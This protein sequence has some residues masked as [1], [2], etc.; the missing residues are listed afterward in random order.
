MTGDSPRLE[1]GD[2]LSY[3]LKRAHADLAVLHEQHL[4]PFGINAGELAVLMLIQSREPE[5]Q[6]RVARR[7][8]IDRTTMVELI[9]VLE[10]KDLVTRRPDTVDRRRKVLTL[11]A[12][13]QATLPRAVQA[14][15]QAEQQLLVGLEEDERVLLRSLLRRIASASGQPRGRRAS[16][17]PSP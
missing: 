11:T 14:S 3:L 7:L 17:G 16:T 1:V 12:Q 9:D 4:A 10:Y 5:S 8:G 6:Q 15:D 2:R 13:G